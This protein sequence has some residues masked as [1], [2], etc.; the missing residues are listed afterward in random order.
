MIGAAGLHCLPFVLG[1]WAGILGGD[2]LQKCLAILLA[3]KYD[4]CYSKIDGFLKAMMLLAIATVT[5]MMRMTD[6][7][8]Q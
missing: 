8:S 1:G 6:D 3:K 4:R 5:V 7:A 2:G